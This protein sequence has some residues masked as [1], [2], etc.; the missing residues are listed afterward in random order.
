V[1]LTPVPPRDR[2]GLPEALIG[3][4]RPV[5]TFTAL[6]LAAC[7]GFALFQSA[8]GHFLPHDVEFLGMDARALCALQQCRIVHFMFH[9]RVAFGGVLIAV[10]LLYAWL[11]E[12]P[13][14]AGEA[15]AWWAF[16]ISGACGFA[17][18]L[19]YIGYGYLDTWHG[20]ATLVLLALFALGLRRS[21]WTL[22]ATSSATHRCVPRNLGAGRLLLLATGL[23]FVGA[24]L[25]ISAVGSTVVF[26][27]QD[28][29]FMGLSAPDLR[30]INPR[31]VPLIAH[32]RAGFGGALVTCGVAWLFC[33]WYGEPS[34][35][36]WQTLLFAGTFGFACAIGIHLIVGY[37]DLLHLAPAILGAVLF[38][39]AIALSHKPMCAA[40]GPAARSAA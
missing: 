15:W 5:L 37:L 8:T 30:A 4:G 21:R 31:L 7:G 19:T 38:V 3:D 10:G 23:G 26:V 32:D 27:P 18:F 33:V 17:S 35:S 2:R 20:A 14:R 11:A 34:R 12:F 36:L 25:T 6:A 28:L 16:A 9:D 29:A 39:V 1:A 40:E 22:A 13:L 24:G